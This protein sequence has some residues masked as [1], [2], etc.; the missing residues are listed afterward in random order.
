MSETSEEKDMIAAR[1]RVS[2]EVF[3]GGE[4]LLL[5][6]YFG[7]SK[8]VADIRLRTSEVWDVHNKKRL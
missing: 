7:R 5:R 4:G 1:N 6:L 3:R 8:K 2:R